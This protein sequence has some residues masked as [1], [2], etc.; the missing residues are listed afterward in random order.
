MNSYTYDSKT[1]SFSLDILNTNC[2]VL[3]NITLRKGRKYEAL[4]FLQTTPQI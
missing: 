3:Q 1:E 2:L 4:L